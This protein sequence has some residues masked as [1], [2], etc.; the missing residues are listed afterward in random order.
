M[1]RI[2]SD[3]NYSSPDGCVNCYKW[4]DAEYDAIQDELKQLED[5]DVYERVQ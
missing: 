5:E 4:E 3:E 2:C 1:C